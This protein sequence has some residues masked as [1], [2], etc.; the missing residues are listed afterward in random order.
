[1]DVSVYAFYFIVPNTLYIFICLM[2]SVFKDV[3]II[4]RGERVCDMV[5]MLIDYL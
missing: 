1:M 2:F 3:V 4:C 5:R